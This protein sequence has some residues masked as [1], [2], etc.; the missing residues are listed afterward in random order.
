VRVRVLVQ[1]VDDGGLTIAES[2]ID[3]RD[4]DTRYPWQSRRL[5][6]RTSRDRLYCGICEAVFEEMRDARKSA[7]RK[8]RR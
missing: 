6:E 4:A 3:Q 5:H 8:A 1:V 2:V 7:R